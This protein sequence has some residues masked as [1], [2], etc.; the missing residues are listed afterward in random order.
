MA[1][2]QTQSSLVVEAIVH[3]DVTCDGCEVE[4][5]AGARC[6]PGCVLAHL[7]RAAMSASVLA[8]PRA[9]KQLGKCS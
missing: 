4:P 2:A 1:N 5:I 7:P 6:D 8:P 9:A 3:L